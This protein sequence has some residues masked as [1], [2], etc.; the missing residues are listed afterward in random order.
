MQSAL[1]Y[2]ITASAELREIIV[3]ILQ[4][5]NQVL[6]FLK[7]KGTFVA[8]NG[9]IINRD[10]NQSIY[11][12]EYQTYPQLQVYITGFYTQHAD[13]FKPAAVRIMRDTDIEVV[14]ELII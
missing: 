5:D 6:E 7:K 11:V 13:V 8:E 12:T 4:C 10:T 2:F 3:T 14:K 9:V 1:S